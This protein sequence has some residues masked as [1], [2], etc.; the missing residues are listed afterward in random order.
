[1]HRPAAP[2]GDAT[3]TATSGGVR[4]FLPLGVAMVLV[5]AACSTAPSNGSSDDPQSSGGDFVYVAASERYGP[6][7]DLAA[8]ASASDAVVQGTVIAV[9]EGRVISYGEPEEPSTQ[10]L[11][12]IVEVT[13]ALSGSVESRTIAIEWLG[14]DNDPENGDRREIIVNGYAAPK[15]GDDVIW[16]LR[17]EDGSVADAVRYGLISFAGRLLVVD[18]KVVSESSEQ[19][20]LNPPAE[21]WLLEDFKALLDS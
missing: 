16:F 10:V 15:V 21:G 14:W 9:Q 18:G 17:R 11:D 13:V 20:G 5:L 8:M 2:V 7:E 12:V 19:T 4:R 6:F 1:M 3:R